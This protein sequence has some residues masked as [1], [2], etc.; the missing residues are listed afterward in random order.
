MIKNDDGRKKSKRPAPFWLFVT[1]STSYQNIDPMILKR[2]N[3]TNRNYQRHKLACKVAA[4]KLKVEIAKNGTAYYVFKS[5]RSIADVPRKR[6][7]PIH[8]K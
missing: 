2:S 4:K 3:E 7:D 6:Y 8:K 5:T 1:E